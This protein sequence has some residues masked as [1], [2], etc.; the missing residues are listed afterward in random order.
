MKRAVC[1]ELF[2]DLSFGDACR[3]AALNGFS[4]MEIAP[5]TLY[6]ETGITPVQTNR[7]F[8]SLREY[9]LDF[10]GFHWLLAWPEGLSFTSG[11]KSLRMKTWN[12]MRDLLSAAGDL[13]GGALVFGSPVQRRV[14]GIPLEDGYSYFTE[15]LAYLADRAVAANSVICIESL[16]AAE[17][18]I[19]NTMAEAKRIVDE[20]SSRG[21]QGMFDFHNCVDETEDWST[22]IRKYIEMIRH[23][24]LNTWEGGHPLA[25]QA[26]EYQEAFAAL[27]REEYEH[28]V[29]L[30]IFTVPK[31]PA[32]VLKETAEF[33]DSLKK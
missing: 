31:N 3:L 2:G 9:G 30:E 28:W 6:R 22:L 12:V 1:N 29:S 18:N 19:L 7:I 26:D 24:H 21:I 16:A 17:T 23:V 15:G 25:A 8:R 10:A 32:Q 4:G 11:D 5:F 33:L 13:G 14:S 20:I 27:H